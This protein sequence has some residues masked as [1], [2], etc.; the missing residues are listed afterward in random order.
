MAGKWSNL[1]GKVPF[2]PT[3]ATYADK[4]R[5]EQKK[6]TTVRVLGVEGVEEQPA[7][8]RDH[9]AS[10]NKLVAEK[11]KNAARDKE[12]E[13]SLTALV[14]LINTYLDSTGS[15]IWRG[16]GYTFSEKTDLYANIAN[17]ADVLE[18]FVPLRAIRT[19]LADLLAKP[20]LKRGEIEEILVSLADAEGKATMLQI[21][22]QTL[23][24]MV[25]AEG[26]AG[27]LIIETIGGDDGTEEQTIVK[28]KIPGVTVFLKTG[29]NRR[30][31]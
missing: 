5:A 22:Y 3:E 12:I 2:A 21:P 9:V 26:E 19:R 6:F 24:A 1:K 4:V 10:Y 16:D 23:N 13:L 8:M 31:T 25:K 29:V 20:K 17:K 30:K 18:H 7:T 28:S 11:E 14:G 15:D 27:E